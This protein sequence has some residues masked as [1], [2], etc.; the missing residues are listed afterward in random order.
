MAK[1]NAYLAKRDARL[2]IDYKLKLYIMQQI[3]MDAAIIAA[4]D[5]LQLGKGRAEQFGARYIEA[6]NEISKLIVDDSKDD[7]DCVYS[8]AVLD[9]Q[10]KS[11]VGEKN[12][13]PW[14]ERYTM[15]RRKLK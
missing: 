7:K 8:R 5:V 15:L 14:E 3:G 9:R 12:F 11:I 13:A 10:I 1:T 4:H 2:E 6:V